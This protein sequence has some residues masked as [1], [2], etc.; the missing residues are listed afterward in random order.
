MT[1]YGDAD[2]MDALTHAHEAKSGARLVAEHPP[3][4]KAAAA[5]AKTA[6]GAPATVLFVMEKRGADWSY[7]VVDE[8]GLLTNDPPECA[9]CHDDAPIDHLYVLPQ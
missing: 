4:S 7:R 5:A 2:G 8:N 6:S 3:L 9:S 1:V